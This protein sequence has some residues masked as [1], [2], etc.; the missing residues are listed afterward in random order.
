M[1]FFAEILNTIRI[2]LDIYFFSLRKL[3]AID[4]NNFLNR[5]GKNT[6]ASHVKEL[7][8]PMVGIP[9]QPLHPLKTC[10]QKNN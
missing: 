6:E 1:T 4:K 5:F 2:I 3:T 8:L 9:G 7:T 10:S